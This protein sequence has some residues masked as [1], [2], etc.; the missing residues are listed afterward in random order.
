MKNVNGNK[1]RNE[2]G[3][4]VCVCVSCMYMCK[5][6]CKRRR[7][8]EEWVQRC[9]VVGGLRSKNVDSPPR[10]KFTYKKEKF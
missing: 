7:A 5:R 6:V 3:G 1:K 9:Q 4:S 2:I 10:S 8:R